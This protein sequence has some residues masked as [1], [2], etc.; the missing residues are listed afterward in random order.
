MINGVSRILENIVY[1]KMEGGKGATYKVT[2]TLHQDTAGLSIEAVTIE[3]MVIEQN[4]VDPEVCIDN[5]LIRC[6]YFPQDYIK[7]LEHTQDLRMTIK[8]ERW[9]RN[10]Y[11]VD[12]F[13][14]PIINEYRVIINNPQDLL[15][16]VPPAVLKKTED[17]NY[18]RD[19]LNDPLPLDMQLV[20]DID[21]EGLKMG[22]N[23]ILADTDVI[24][25]ILYYCKAVGIK[26]T[27][28]VEPKNLNKVESITIPAI[29]PL[30]QLI[31][32]LQKY[33]G[34][35][36]KGAT[37][38]YTNGTLYV[39]PPF[40]T[41][42]DVS[43]IVNIFRLPEN[44]VD[45]GDQYH[46]QIDDELYIVSF[47]K[48]TG[49]NTAESSTEN[50]GNAVTIKQA[51]TSI[52]A[53][54]N[55][56]D[57]GTITLNPQNT[58]MA[59]VNNSSTNVPNQ[60]NAYHGGTTSNIFDQVSVI[61]AG[62]KEMIGLGWVFAVPYLITPGMKVILHYDDTSAQNEEDFYSTTPGIVDYVKYDLVQHGKP[63]YIVYRW[64]ATIAISVPPKERGEGQTQ[65]PVPANSLEDKFKSLERYIEE[66]SHYT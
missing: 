42:P 51:D 26:K 46:N 23:F 38:Y 16:Q 14:D 36:D 4:F 15:K 20:P 49:E 34:I 28:I 52:G 61:A 11:S 56:S 53:G 48:V 60:V 24:S 55:I 8:Q 25:A 27:H 3:G 33:P 65:E 50:I 39:Y 12:P 58:I 59:K 31:P 57:D 41:D 19:Q 6:T 40:D 2:A 32:T 37:Q 17:M 35:Y 18:D 21:Y 44:S 9:E 43:E 47:S 64:N 7:I 1:E 30:A 62:Q 54:A 29:T 5:I 22:G 10:Y 66:D 13:T 45:G 63:S